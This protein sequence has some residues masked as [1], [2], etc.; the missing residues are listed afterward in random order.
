MR[1]KNLAAGI[2]SGAAALGVAAILAGTAQAA[3]IAA[4]PTAAP[5]PLTLALIGAGLT[6]LGLVRRRRA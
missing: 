5:E 2:S 3:P 6:A 4:G 1:L